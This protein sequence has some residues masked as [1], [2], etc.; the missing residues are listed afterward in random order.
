MRGIAF[1]VRLLLLVSMLAPAAVRAEDIEVRHVALRAA[2]EGL[3]L[4]A[5]FEVRLTPRLA[6]VLANGVPLYFQVEFELKRPRWYWLDE[7]TASK[8]LQLRLSYHALSRQYRLST[9][10]LQQNFPT[11][12]DAL[13][14]LARV[15]NWLVVER[16]VSLAEVD[17]EAAV[18]MRFDTGMLPKPFQLSA[19]TSRELQL[20]SSWRRFTLRSPRHAPAPVEARDPQGAQQ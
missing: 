11:L 1:F 10:M 3:L 13:N 14:V 8:R 2:E 6:D 16:T 15:R 9:G 18:R 4:D 7:K 5:D 12:E 19:L 17:Y 20:E